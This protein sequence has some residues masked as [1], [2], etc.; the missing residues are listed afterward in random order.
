VYTGDW[1]D[2]KCHGHGTYTFADSTFYEGN[3]TDNTFD[4]DGA[5]VFSLNEDEAQP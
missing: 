5:M 4:G 1:R 3:W 2:D